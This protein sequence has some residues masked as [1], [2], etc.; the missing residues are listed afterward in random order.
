MVGAG[1]GEIPEMFIRSL[2]HGAADP[3]ACGG[4]SANPLRDRRG[5]VAAFGAIIRGVHPGSG[6]DRAVLDPPRGVGRQCRGRQGSRQPFS[7]FGLDF[8]GGRF[9]GEALETGIRSRDNSFDQRSAPNF[10]K[11][12]NAGSMSPI[13][14]QQECWLQLRIP[15]FE[16][17]DARLLVGSRFG[18]G[19][20]H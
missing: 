19:E 17:I 14:V 18:L 20:P 7:P 8:R 2:R 3:C 1:N 13:A 15:V 16:G 9:L 4:W 11:D 12:G 6:L 5:R 10:R